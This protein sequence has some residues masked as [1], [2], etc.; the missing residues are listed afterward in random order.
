M[1][2]IVRLTTKFL[3]ASNPNICFIFYMVPYR[4]DVSLKIAHI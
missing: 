4:G 2:R 1:M 3:A